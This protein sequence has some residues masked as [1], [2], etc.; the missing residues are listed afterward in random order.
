MTNGPMYRIGQGVDVH[1]FDDNS[2]QPLILGGVRFEADRGLA[3]HS[4]ADVVAH[5]CADALLGAAGLGD[6][7]QHFPD[8]DPQWEGA[9]SFRILAAVVDLLS[10]SGW[11]PVNVDCTV[12]CERPR[13]TA[14]REAMQRNLEGALGAPVNVKAST[15]ERL[16]AVGRQEGIACMAVALISEAEL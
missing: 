4:D 3:G 5:A 15:T 6:I 1:A 2:S 9:D 7:G 8:H 14:R 12:L 16:G 10:E 13:L 11:V